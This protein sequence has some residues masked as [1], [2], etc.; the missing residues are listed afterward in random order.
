MGCAVKFHPVGNGA[1]RS[2]VVPCLIRKGCLGAAVRTRK[3]PR[4]SAQLPL[5]AREVWGHIQ[6]APHDAWGA[7]AG[8]SALESAAW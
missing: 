1:T 2:S 4:P 3:A 5:L 7:H 6:E 8:Q